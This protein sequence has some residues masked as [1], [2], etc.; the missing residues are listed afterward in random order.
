VL[1]HF[2]NDIDEWELYDL[3]K[4]PDEVKNVYGDPAYAEVRKDLT[5]RLKSLRITYWEKE[6][7]QVNANAF[8]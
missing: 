4:D 5:K 1:I 7:L 6:D 3:Q 8:R 2:Y